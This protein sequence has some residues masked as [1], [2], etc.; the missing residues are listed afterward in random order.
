MAD[1][2]FLPDGTFHPFSAAELSTELATRSNA[3]V[4][5]GEL[6]GWLSTLPDP[7]PVLRKRGD[8]AA[9][10]R[11]LSADEQVTTAMLSR[12]NRVLN[13]PHFAF[14]AGSPEGETPTPQAEDLHRRFMTDL[15]RTNL[16]AII[17]GM[18]D[19]P[20]YGFTP[21]E[22]VWRF[23]GDWWHLV[24]IVPKPFHWFRFGSRNNP[25]F[26]GEYGLFCADPRPLPPGK[27]VFV[28]H[29]ASYDNPYGL[30]L[31]SRCLWPV[32]FK[33]GGLTFY[34][35]F[36]ERHGLPWVVGEAPARAERLEKQAM[37]RD[38]SRMVQDAVAV[39]PHG[40]SVKLESAGQTQGALHEDF[41]ARQDRAISKVLMGQTLTVETDGKNSLAAT[42]AH[43]DVA[44]DLADADKFM[45][46]DAWN[47]IAW[48]YAQVNA[49]PGVLA[50][51]AAYD[52]PEDL[53]TRADL[54][55]KLTEIGVRFTAEHF[56]TNYGL[57]ANEFSVEAPP[58]R[59]GIA[60]FAAPS[61]RMSP[62]EMAQS[63]LDAAIVKMLPRAL[64]ASA[65]F[66]TKLENEIRAAK[67]YEDL[68]EALVALLSP[69]LSSD[70]LESFLAR[71]MT[72]AAGLGAAAV[73]AEGEEDG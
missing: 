35:R 53:N 72:A 66:V 13:C 6:E 16:R 63:R 60:D 3:G 26:V 12:K 54:D 15:E 30:R 43:K 59:G 68:E 61:G 70:A 2:L 23:S 55:K 14:R 31:L 45:V 22:L 57:K 48:L 62:A 18:L 19:A 9:I 7:D 52:E 33:R 34:A 29:H 51:L 42:K 28:T 49:G 10:L 1:G 11:E 8:D 44:D 4:L 50:P 65:D 67:S 25:V 37:A 40:A 24:D 5:F 69:S 58:T 41:L 56:T 71:A 73:Q 39:I 21:L 47:E 46:T 20:Y 27:F 38:L 17:S 36:V 64:R 32:S